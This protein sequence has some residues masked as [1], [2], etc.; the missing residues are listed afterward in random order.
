MSLASFC[1]ILPYLASSCLIFTRNR[2]SLSFAPPI[3]YAM[4]FYLFFYVFFIIRFISTSPFDCHLFFCPLSPPPLGCLLSSFIFALSDRTTSNFRKMLHASGAFPV[5]F[6]RELFQHSNT[7]PP[8]GTYS[9]VK[10][11]SF[12]HKWTR[13]MTWTVAFCSFGFNQQV[14]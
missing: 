11:R 14:K 8:L 7:I 9:C 3:P 6:P 10:C 2:S 12:V 13:G 4:S 1:L 5:Y